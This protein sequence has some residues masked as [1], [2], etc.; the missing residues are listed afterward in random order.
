MGCAADAGL[1]LSCEHA[2]HPTKFTLRSG[3]VF[4][5]SDSA[6]SECLV[7]RRSVFS[8]PDQLSKSREYEFFHVQ[9][10]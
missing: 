7:E 6:D 5:G 8:V 1:V 10:N 4:C 9:L 3:F 2:I